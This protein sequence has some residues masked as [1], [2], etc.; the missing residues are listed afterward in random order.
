MRII[1]ATDVHHAFRGV[2][3]LL[4]N[5]SADIYLICG[6]LVARAFATYKDAW[7]FSEAAEDVAEGSRADMRSFSTN[8]KLIDRARAILEGGRKGKIRHSAEEYIRLAEVAVKYLLGSY[9]RLEKILAARPEK[10][11]FVLPGNYDTD[12]AGTALKQRDLH[13]RSI[14]SLGIRI[15]GYGGARISTPGIPEHL[16]VPYDEN[17]LYSFLSQT[18]PNILVLHQPAYGFLDCIP[19][20]GNTGC[21]S[22]RRHIDEGRKLVVL[23]GHNH[24]SWGFE[25]CDGSYFI[26]PSNFGNAAEA[27]GIRPGGYFLDLCISGTDIERAS[28]RR[29]EKGK[30]FTIIEWL[31][32][33]EKT[34]SVILDEQRY[35]LA[36]GK[37]PRITHSKPIRELLRIK[38]FFLNYETPEA[39]ELIAK[40]RE[41]YR[42]IEKQSMEVGFDLLGSVNFGMAEK[43]SDLDLVVYMRSRDCVLDEEDTCGVPRPLRAVFDALKEKGVETEVCDSIDLDRVAD[44]ILREDMEDGH[45]QRFIFYRMVC[46]AV[47]LRL[48]K[49]VENLL[50]TR[51]SFRLRVEEKLGE[52]LELLVSSGRHVQ[53]FDKYRSRLQ[54]R[55]IRIPSDIEEAIGNYL[56][57]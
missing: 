26:N 36:G 50:L 6:D 4:D 2:G 57:K 56:R 33:K 9:V 27:S 20:Y 10:R 5:T 54:E 41:I 28:M 45:L 16:Q 53:S 23:S 25:R 35:A 3:E 21:H 43:H 24:E 34:D 13:K 30:P 37:I 52:Y 18:A 46:R 19:C 51:E 48:I 15:A 40:L 8:L 1:F 55:G 14:E 31:P 22:V 42:D 44:A 29:L 32:V 49:R 39:K 7:R 12:L 11:V 38:K 17:E 47:N